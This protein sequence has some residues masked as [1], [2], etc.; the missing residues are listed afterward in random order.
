MSKAGIN[1]V[2]CDEVYCVFTATVSSTL[3][4][5]MRAL[6]VELWRHILSHVWAKSNDQIM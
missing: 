3:L 5:T 4:T 2:Y 6:G 1:Q